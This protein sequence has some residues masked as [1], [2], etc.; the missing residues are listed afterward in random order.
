MMSAQAHTQQRQV[1]TS[2]TLASFKDV[3]K[4]ETIIVCGCGESLNL[5]EHPERFVTIGVNDIGRRFHPDYL[6]VVNPCSQFSGD[7]F[8]YVKTSRARY[9]FS[10]YDD[11]RVP[12]PQLVKFKLGTRGGTDFSNPNVLHFTQNSPYVALCLAIHMGAKRIGLIGVDFTEAH[13]FGKIGTHPLA[14][15]LC[16]IDREYG[17][18]AQACRAMDIELVNL[19]PISRLNSL[20]RVELA[21]LCPST[22]LARIVAAPQT[23][24]ETQPNPRRLFV[25]NYRFLSC[26]DVFTDGLR[27]GA[28]DLDLA[29]QDACWD[30]AQLPAMIERFQPDLVL[31]VHGRRFAQKWR[32]RFRAFN[33]AVWLVDE[34]YEVDDTVR[35]SSLFGTVFVNDPNTLERHRN[36]HYLPVCFDPRVHQDAG[37]QRIYPAGFIGGFN[38]ARERFLLKLAEAGLL[39][40]LVG[41]P[42]HSPG[43]R[44]LCLA[45]TVP[46]A[47]TAQLYQQTDIVLNVFRETHHYNA[48]KIAAFAMNPRIYEALA[49]GAAVVSERRAEVG[50]VFPELPQFATPDELVTQVRELLA[51][52]Q[53]LT[54]VRERCRARLPGHAYKD[55]LA[56]V[57]ATALG[58]DG[59]AAPVHP[60]PAPARDKET[61][62]EA[63]STHQTYP[64]PLVGRGAPVAAASQ[65]SSVPAVQFLPLGAATRR[66]LVYHVWPVRGS[67]WRWN[68]DELKRCRSIWRA[69]ASSTSS[70][71][72]TGAAKRRRFH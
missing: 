60:V 39:G 20:V 70:R 72:T 13:F 43:L 3:H 49:C 32:D 11:L 28:E 40:Y 45:S 58:E 46:A 51:D 59:A 19:S 57:L 53:C 68:L 71:R 15:R 2:S 55:R 65:A 62:M 9:L 61:A 6:V 4:G 44:K 22:T 50:Q 31:V 7:R 8:D 38:A 18:L 29:Y 34:P 54:E 52:R 14:G 33:T 23:R 48:K 47:Q 12:H 36:A 37:K 10:Q 69:T 63:A 35:W 27:Q 30:D 66:N 26:G 16:Q 25:V 64:A 56:H 42:W 24:L 17:A 67:T 5:L 21:R 1:A 41:G